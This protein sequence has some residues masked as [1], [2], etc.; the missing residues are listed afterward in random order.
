MKQSVSAQP[1]QP[2]QPAQSSRF[3]LLDNFNRLREVEV[4]ETGQRLVTVKPVDNAGLIAWRCLGMTTFEERVMVRPD[5]LAPTDDPD[6]AERDL[7]AQREQYRA[8]IAASCQRY[9][10]RGRVY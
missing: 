4:V 6:Q 1:A 5:E 9:R 7:I 8:Q 3:F 2:A 10:R